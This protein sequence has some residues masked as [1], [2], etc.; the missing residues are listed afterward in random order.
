MSEVYDLR[1]AFD[2]LKTI[3]GEFVERDVEVDP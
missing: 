1:S 3:P 2:L